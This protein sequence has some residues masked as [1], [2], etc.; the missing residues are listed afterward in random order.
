[1]RS[2]TEQCLHEAIRRWIIWG[3]SDSH[4]GTMRDC[5]TGLGSRSK[6][7]EVLEDGLMEW[8]NEPSPRCTGWLKLTAKGE[9]AVRLILKER[10]IKNWELNL[11]P[12]N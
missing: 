7:K 5:W 11:P 8:V 1:M 12:K 3:N 4:N 10:L 2:Q 6:Y 9:N